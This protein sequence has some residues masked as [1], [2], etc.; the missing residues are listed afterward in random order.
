MRV[1]ILCILSFFIHQITFCQNVGIGIATPQGKLHISGGY[2]T[3]G[4]SAPVN[5]LYIN[6]NGASPNAAQVVWGDNTGWRLNFGTI[7]GGSFQP[8]VT[9]VDVGNVGIGT[10]N[11]NARLEVS[12]TATATTEPQLRLFNPNT[13]IGTTTGLRMRTVGGWDIKLQTVENTDW[14]QIT[15]GGGGV[16]H[17]YQG[18]R[19]YPGSTS[20]NG[21]NTGYITGNGTNIAVGTPTPNASALLHI[22]SAT[23]GVLLPQVSLIAANN[24]APIT[25]APATGLLVYNTATSGTGV[26]VVTPGH[27]YWDGTRWQRFQTNAYAGIVQGV[28]NPADVDLTTNAPAFQYTTASITLPPGKW[29]VFANVLLNP[30]IA[31]SSGACWVRSSFSESNVTFSY[32]PDIIGS[33]L[34]SGSLIAP[35]VYGLVTGQVII[36]NTSGAN[37]IY[38]YWANKENMGGYTGAINGFAWSAWGENQ[39]FAVP[40][41]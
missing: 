4:M 29:V 30:T 26:N 22:Q 35:C 1:I 6:A 32:S 37:K 24:P 18:N 36:N 40:A 21:T 9:M 41:N 27:Y 2:A 38:Y 33:P 23:K 31:F 3:T 20:N 15:D 25:P 5:S 14:L 28:F 39:L 10:V 7:A 19:Y 17:A 12:N 13:G 8:R 11:P 34:I 16:Q